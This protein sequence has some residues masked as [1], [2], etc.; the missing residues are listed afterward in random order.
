MPI[1]LPVPLPVPDPARRRVH[2][3]PDAA[4]TPHVRRARLP[5]IFPAP[6]ELRPAVAVS[7]EISADG[8]GG[9]FDCSRGQVLRW[10]EAHVGPLPASFDRGIHVAGK[11]CHVER[12]RAAGAIVRAVDREA[13][14]RRYFGVSIEAGAVAGLAAWKAVVV[15][16]RSETTSYLRAMLLAPRRRLQQR[17]AALWVPGIV[18]WLA[19]SPGI[20]DY[21]WRLLPEPWIIRNEE[22]IEGLIQLIGS[23][24]RTRPL[25]ATGLFPHETDPESAPIDPWDLAHRT[26]GIGHV[27]VLTGP[28][29]YALTD[30]VGRKYSVFGNA[31]RTYR[32]GCVIGSG[33]T[34]HP[35][36]LPDTVRRW[37]NGGPHEFA[38]FLTREAARA[39]VVH[40]QPG[41]SWFPESLAGEI[42]T[43][44]GDA[45]VSDPFG[46]ALLRP[47]ADGDALH[48]LGAGDDSAQ[49]ESAGQEEASAPAIRAG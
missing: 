6:S 42:A 38:V 36:A 2:R 31:L 3:V 19:R 25:F 45:P 34:E 20:T 47:G 46:D 27:A 5:D 8:E 22:G 18:H 44:N 7:A 11:G 29:T 40:Q 10:V 35:M 37:R 15:L 41:A 12:H 1:P 48:P 43:L 30:R 24:D 32:P 9:E 21:G 28:M 49:G 26:V 13:G 39:S 14:S 33:A 17:T 4:R 16:F 23:R